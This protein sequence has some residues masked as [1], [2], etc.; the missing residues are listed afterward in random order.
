VEQLQPF[1]RQLARQNGG[2]SEIRA[3]TVEAGNKTQCDRV[4]AG[5]KDDRYSRRRCFRGPR[6]LAGA[7]YDHRNAATDAIGCNY[8]QSIILVLRTPI[9]DRNVLALDIAGFL[10]ALEK[11]NPHTPLPYESCTVSRATLPS[12]TQ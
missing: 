12:G 7:G 10:Q 6:C 1:R 5:G 8:R 3:G 9:L 4:T 2:P 11:R